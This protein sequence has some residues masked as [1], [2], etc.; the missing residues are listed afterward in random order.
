[1]DLFFLNMRKTT[2]YRV[3]N[4]QLY[5]VGCVKKQ[6]FYSQKYQAFSFGIYNKDKFSEFESNETRSIH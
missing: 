3:F 5:T 6:F 1:M 4:V 2:G